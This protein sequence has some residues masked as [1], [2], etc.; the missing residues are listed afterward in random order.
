MP[1]PYRQTF[2]LDLLTDEQLEQVQQLAAEAKE[3]SPSISDLL[4]VMI[5]KVVAANPKLDDQVEQ[6]KAA[7]DS[8][9]AKMLAMPLSDMTADDGD[10]DDSGFDKLAGAV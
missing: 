10:D 2:L 7:N 5:K 1:N 6:A 4:S 3:D 9:F 8:S